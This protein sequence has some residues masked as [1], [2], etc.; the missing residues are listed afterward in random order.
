MAT[1]A[2]YIEKKLAGV[3]TRAGCSIAASDTSLLCEAHRRDAIAREVRSK[4]KARRARRA[5]GLCAECGVV[6]TK[7][8]RCSSCLIRLGKL[9]RPMVDTVVDK[10]TRVASR[11]TVGSFA[12]EE[13]RS[14]YRGAQARR[15]PPGVAREDA[16][17]FSDAIRSI[18]R[19]RDGVAHAHSDEVKQ[20]P[21]AQRQDVMRRALSQADHGARFIES[22]L[23]RHRYDGRM[24]EKDNED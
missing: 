23:E 13:G 22:I 17:D 11:I 18:E 4:A 5:Q 7:R 20:M 2:T 21:L 1:A 10:R 12:K 15:G 19:G 6:K 3:C 8:Y 14:R 16:A 9:R 24:P